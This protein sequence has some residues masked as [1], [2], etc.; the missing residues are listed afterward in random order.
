MP[1]YYQIVAY[2][3]NSGFDSGFAGGYSEY[4]KCGLLSSCPDDHT[5]V[6]IYVTPGFTN[7]NINPGDWY[8]PSGT[9][10]EDPTK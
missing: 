7:Q 2:E 6:T 9:F 10:P 3:K 8:A 4:A 1:G 5:L